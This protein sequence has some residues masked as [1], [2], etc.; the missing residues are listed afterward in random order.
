MCVW[1]GVELNFNLSLSL[2][3]QPISGVK[4]GL[5]RFLLPRGMCA[6]SALV[7]DEVEACY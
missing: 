1:G 2:M 7:D 6:P 5:S 4:S 3:R